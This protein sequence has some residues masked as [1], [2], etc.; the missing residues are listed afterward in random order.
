MKDQIEATGKDMQ[1][2]SQT[3]AC[4]IQRKALILSVTL[5]ASTYAT[6]FIRELLKVV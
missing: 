5:K 3:E 2:A 4:V 1:G 6:M